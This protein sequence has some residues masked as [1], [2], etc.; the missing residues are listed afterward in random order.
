VQAVEGACACGGPKAAVGEALRYR[1]PD[2][3]PGPPRRFSAFGG[4]RHAREAAETLREVARKAKRSPFWPGQA[5]PGAQEER[6]SP[7]RQRT[8]EF[9]DEL[10]VR[11]KTPRG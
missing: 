1:P 6:L 5:L 8:R 7:P 10:Y 4:T 9:C 11:R 3:D 2:T